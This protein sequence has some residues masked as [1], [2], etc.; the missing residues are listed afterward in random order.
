M[1]TLQEKFAIWDAVSSKIEM[2]EKTIEEERAKLSTI[3]QSISDEHGDGPHDKD[4][5]PTVVGRRNSTYF[6]RGP[7]MGRGPGKKNKT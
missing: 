6:L 2:M 3:A 5:A 1:S 4:G 7:Y